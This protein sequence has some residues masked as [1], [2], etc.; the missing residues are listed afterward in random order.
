MGRPFSTRGPVSAY[1]LDQT[2]PGRL[3]FDPLESR[4]ALSLAAVQK[5]KAVIFGRLALPRLRYCGLDRPC[6]RAGI[7][8]Q[9]LMAFALLLSRELSKPVLRS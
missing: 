6:R 1:R 3:A 5:K 9:D 8:F 7:S 4:F 2:T